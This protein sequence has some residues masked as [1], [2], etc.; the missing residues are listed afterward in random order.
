[1]TPYS[2]EHIFTS[3]SANAFY[4]VAGHYTAETVL[5][6]FDRVRAYWPLHAQSNLPGKLMIV[7]ALKQ[8]SRRPD[9]LAWLVV[10]VSNLGGVLMYVFVR[11]LFAD[12]RVA[13]YSL[14]LYLFVPAKLFFFPLLNTVR[15]VV[16]LAV[17]VWCSDGS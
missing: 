15:P 9:I 11:D 17:P 12:R 8:I 4:G 7:Y 2:F 5:S 10:L 16:V 14:V 1:M 3:D 13:L 6:D